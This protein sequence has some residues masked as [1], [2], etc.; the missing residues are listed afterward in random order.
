MLD[1]FYLLLIPALYIYCTGFCI[2]KLLTGNNQ[3][4]YFAIF[5]PVL[6]TAFCT[7]LQLIMLQLNLILIAKVVY[8]IAGLLAV[9]Y[10]ALSIKKDLT[11]KNK[12]IFQFTMPLSVLL[13]SLFIFL[14]QRL[15]IGWGVVPL[16]TLTDDGFG[17]DDTAWHAAIAGMF[18]NTL[19]ILHPTLCGEILQ[20]SHFMIHCLAAFYSI[21]LERNSLDI[22]FFSLPFVIIL[23]LV[24][25][26]YIFF[27]FVLK[28]SRRISI[29][30]T[31]SACLGLSG[32]FLF[33]PVF[34]LKI[35]NFNPE[36]LPWIFWRLPGFGLSLF[37]SLPL[38]VILSHSKGHDLK[39]SA[40]AFI[41]FVVLACG[42]YAK[43]AIPISI[44]AAF[45]LFCF[46]KKACGE[47]VDFPIFS[48][49]IIFSFIY[50][51][52]F[53]SGSDYGFDAKMPFLPFATFFSIF[54]KITASFK[55]DNFITFKTLIF[56]CGYY[57][58]T[59]IAFCNAFKNNKKLSNENLLL[60][61]SSGIGF[62]CFLFLYSP[63]GAEYQFGLLATFLATILYFGQINSKTDKMI[64]TSLFIL[65]G[66]F[67]IFH[68]CINSFSADV[69]SDK[70][71][72]NKDIVEAM[73]WLHKNSQ[74]NEGF[75]VNDQHYRSQMTNNA[76]YCA[77]SE[78]QSYISCYRYTPETYINSYR[79]KPSPWFYRLTNNSKIFN[80]D[81]EIM[82]TEAKRLNIQHLVVNKNIKNFRNIETNKNLLK[83]FENCQIAIYKINLRRN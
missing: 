67:Y 39:T 76:V 52:F 61:L 2:L 37:F 46:Y 29:A 83:K 44:L 59:I 7:A 21:L 14:T 73:F 65:S 24:W 45:C 25:Q 36:P 33:F 42:L 41:L 68:F 53:L 20:K 22:F 1:I 17:M 80:G 82:K 11:L 19:P 54:E 8:L 32:A 23:F 15:T 56:I 79:G 13:I 51:C 30:G 57:I 5:T 31:L 64:A 78:R 49:S 55:Q 47:K 81:F 34:G 74:K 26:T 70:K 63:M 38:I 48:A 6:G 77:I 18:K 43:P 40:K 72:V 50:Y 3:E 35:V 16:R 66:S 58:F 60:L 12:T 75:F 4:P 71:E 28:Q 10:L 62:L 69:Y 27:Y 9:G